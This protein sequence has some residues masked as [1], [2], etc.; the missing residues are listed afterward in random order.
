MAIYEITSPQC[1]NSATIEVVRE[2]R[3]IIRPSSLNNGLPDI[4]TM[5][6]GQIILLAASTLTDDAVI[7]AMIENTSRVIERAFRNQ[8]HEYALGKLEQGYLVDNTGKTHTG[9]TRRGARKLEEVEFITRDGSY[10]QT[11][12]GYDI[13]SKG[14]RGQ[15]ITTKG[16]NQYEYFHTQHQNANRHNRPGRTTVRIL[17][18][19]SLF[20]NTLSAL[21]VFSM[22]AGF[23]HTKPLPMPFIPGADVL[24]MMAYD[25][26]REMD[27]LMDEWAEDERQRILSEAKIEGVEKVREVVESRG[28]NHLFFDREGRSIYDLLPITSEIAAQ[29][30]NEE[31]KCISEVREA[32]SK[33]NPSEQD[34]EILFRE[35]VHP[36]NGRRVTIIEAFFIN[37]ILD[38]I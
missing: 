29:I 34:T 13:V 18:T 16:I 25:K 20:G 28:R 2:N 17:R 15:T 35:T 27:R 3:L 30:M 21:E 32:V 6:G 23:D 24:G 5:D 33:T 31:F 9:T 19:L 8:S 1:R 36:A 12:Q 26:F 37:E 14:H 38:E 7:D 11:R 10:V 4:Y 22:S